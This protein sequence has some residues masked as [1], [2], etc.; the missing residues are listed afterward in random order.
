MRMNFSDL[1]A[2]NGAVRRKAN[3]RRM[4]GFSSGKRQEAIFIIQTRG[5]KHNRKSNVKHNYTKFIANTRRMCAG[6]AA[7]AKRCASGALQSHRAHKLLARF[8]PVW[9]NSCQADIGFQTIR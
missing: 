8:Y 9:R 3:K 1:H 6:Q 4:L 2:R 7:Q 5:V